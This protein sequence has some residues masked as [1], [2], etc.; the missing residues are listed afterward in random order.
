MLDQVR[1][2][3]AGCIV[4]RCLSIGIVTQLE[5]YVSTPKKLQ[6]ECEPVPVEMYVL[7]VFWKL[8]SWKEYL[9]E[10][11]RGRGLSIRVERRPEA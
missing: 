9:R 5:S 8:M 7:D 1:E 2:V 3:Q 10:T 6:S 4:A 11:S